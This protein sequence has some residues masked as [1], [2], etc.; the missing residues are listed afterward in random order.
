MFHHRRS[1]LRVPEGNSGTPL[2]VGHEGRSEL[3]VIRHPGIICGRAHELG[4]PGPVLLRDA[5]VN[6]LAQHPFVAPEFFAI[7]SRTAKHLT[8]PQ[9]H[10]ATVVLMDPTRKEGSKQFVLFH[11]V[12]EGIDHSGEGV[13]AAGPFIERRRSGHWGKNSPGATHVGRLPTSVPEGGPAGSRR[14]TGLLCVARFPIAPLGTWHQ[15]AQKWWNHAPLVLGSGAWMVVAVIAVSQGHRAAANPAAGLDLPQLIVAG[16]ALRSGQGV[17]QVHPAALNPQ[18]VYPPTAALFGMAASYF[19]VHQV[20]E[21]LAYV[22]TAEIAVTVFLFR[23]CPRP[24]RWHLLAS[25]IV[26]ALL[27]R[28]DVATTSLWLGNIDFLLIL[29]CAY[30]VLCWGRGRWI[31]GGVALAITLLIKPVLLPLLLVPLVFRAWRSVAITAAIASVGVLVMLPFVGDPGAMPGVLTKVGEG[32]TLARRTEVYNLSLA[33]LGHVHH[34]NSTVTLLARLAVVGVVFTLVA[35]T[36]SR[37]PRQSL[38][39]VGPVTGVILGGVFLAGSLSESHYLFFLIPG[40]MCAVSVRSHMSR[41]LLGG[42]L[43]TAAYSSAYTD[44]LG[45][46]PV[47]GQARFVLTQSLLFAGCA[48]ASVA[49]LR[50][51]GDGGERVL[52]TARAPVVDR[53]SMSL[54][55]TSSSPPMD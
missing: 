21:L 9:S 2:E 51:E 25:A 11:P 55:A 8:P 45:V 13:T 3:G 4:E 20:M 52:A 43:L 23:R 30:V 27:L 1:R 41:L 36:V 15:L 39:V 22:A 5:Q 49:G 14:S 42:A 38:A 37:R 53:E 48:W 54:G 47:D 44:V 6:V 33:A 24:I 29:P 19:R 40:A 46:S 10:M 16:Q 31:L 7:A 35:I 28:G 34:V 17:Y 26:A 50:G 12:V 18:F 32:Q